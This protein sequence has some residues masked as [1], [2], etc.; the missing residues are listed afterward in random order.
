M[1]EG[2]RKKKV[3]NSC[4]GLDSQF[5]CSILLDKSLNTSVSV[6]QFVIQVYTTIFVKHFAGRMYKDGKRVILMSNLH[7]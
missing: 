5:C 3:E 7:K 4:I 6:F 1:L 2:L